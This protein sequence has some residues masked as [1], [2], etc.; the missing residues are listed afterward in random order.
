M[1]GDE[2]SQRK[3]ESKSDWIARRYCSYACFQ[4]KKRLKILEEIEHHLDK[5]RPLTILTD[6][7]GKIFAYRLIKPVIIK[8][9]YIQE[10]IDYK[11]SLKNYSD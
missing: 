3:T 2:Y 10:F 8:D 4:K 9:F 1:C 11:H 5:D 7:E 6:N